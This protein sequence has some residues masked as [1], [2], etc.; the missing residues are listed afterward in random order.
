[1][2]RGRKAITTFGEWHRVLLTRSGREGTLSVDGEQ[3]PVRGSV[4]GRFQGLD[5]ASSPLYVGGV[6]KEISSGSGTGYS[7]G[8]VGKCSSFFYTTATGTTG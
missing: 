1:M 2:V 3:P 6:P 7:N 8:F 4:A 5:V